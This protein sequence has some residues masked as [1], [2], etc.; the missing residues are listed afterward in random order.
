[1]SSQCTWNGITWFARA[2]RLNALKNCI[3]VAVVRHI[4]HPPMLRIF[5][6]YP[7]YAYASSTHATHMHH[8]PKL[9]MF[10]IHPCYAY[11]SSTHATHMRHPFML[12]IFVF[13]PCYTYLSSTHA[14]HICH[15]PMLRIFIIHPCYTIRTMCI[16]TKLMYGVGISLCHAKHDGWHNHCVCQAARQIPFKGAK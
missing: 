15:P 5:V 8:P 2:S 11:L 10:V 7:C 4:H 3:C 12:C 1:V 6:I 9:S 16:S 13:H 14:T